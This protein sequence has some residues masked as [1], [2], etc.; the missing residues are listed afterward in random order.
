[1]TA[2]RAVS[3]LADKSR[4]PL[5]VSQELQGCKLT[6][7]VQDRP[8]TEVLE[9]IGVVLGASWVAVKPTDKADVFYSLERLPEV[10]SWLAARKRADRAAREMARRKRVEA[11]REA[12]LEHIK[13]ADDSN[14]RS[15]GAFNRMAAKFAG[16]LPSEAIEMAAE[17][18]S[19]G[20]PVGGVRNIPAPD[21]KFYT[22]G[23]S[24][25]DAAQRDLL[26]KCV[27]ASPA[28]ASNKILAEINKTN[29]ALTSTDG[30]ILEL[31]LSLQASDG[32]EFQFS[33]PVSSGWAY[34]ME[35][36]F[37]EQERERLMQAHPAPAS[38][39]LGISPDK[40][41]VYRNKVDASCKDL[42][43]Q[44]VSG[45]TPRPLR[46]Q[47]LL[48]LAEDARRNL[49]ADYYTVSERVKLDHPTLGD[50][51]DTTLP[52]LK[53]LAA[54]DG[55]YLLA[56]RLDFPDRDGVEIPYPLPETWIAYKGGDNVTDLPLSASPGRLLN[57]TNLLDMSVQTSEGLFALSQYKDAD[58]NVSL[59]EAT[60]LCDMAYEASARAGRTY[61]NYDL[62]R[63]IA[64]LPPQLR[65][66]LYTEKGV[67]KQSLP[68]PLRQAVE[69]WLSRRA[70]PVYDAPDARLRLCALTM[71]SSAATP[72]APTAP[73]TTQ[74][75]VFR[76]GNGEQ[77]HVAEFYVAPPPSGTEPLR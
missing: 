23:F 70:R 67:L 64:G 60:W 44:Q 33:A 59:D 9:Q 42:L 5:R 58:T 28:G 39:F 76:Q 65:S 66:R 53:T 56:R 77:A 10:R 26:T 45:N 31:R 73:T 11:Q 71:P 51:L 35:T 7:R 52:K 3:L 14:W 22:I 1:M 37:R 48:R 32:R 55:A 16:T 4:L 46:H 25:L 72:S 57:F 61:Q 18:M 50:V 74:L 49:V 43:G 41:G 75:V 29:L 38:A 6:I 15:P 36:P 2:E 63:A 20:T 34:Y 30:V 13:R 69:A 47:L 62:L 12:I 27:M 68:E 8:A 19:S 54:V 21:A 40:G 17:S 24:A